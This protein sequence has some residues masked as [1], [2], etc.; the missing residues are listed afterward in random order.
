MKRESS[1]VPDRLTVLLDQ[2][3]PRAIAS[4]L[5]HIKPTWF[6]HHTNDVGLSGRTDEAV[7]TWAVR[8]KALIISFDE[9]FADDRSF[10]SREHYGIVRL[11]VWP[12]TVEETQDALTRL[13]QE[14]GADELTGSLVIVDRTRIRVRLR[15]SDQEN[16]P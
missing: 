7:F 3:I 9:D 10:P 16:T 2:N 6:I 14:T 4:W 15:R 12:T 8:N 13:I 1:H 5:R 11:R